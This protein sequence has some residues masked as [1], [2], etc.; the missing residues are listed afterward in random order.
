MNIV[1]GPPQILLFFHEIR[2]ILEHLFVS[3]QDERYTKFSRLQ[4]VLRILSS[5][6]KCLFESPLTKITKLGL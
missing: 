4:K 1:I 5:L 6:Q 3:K 2:H